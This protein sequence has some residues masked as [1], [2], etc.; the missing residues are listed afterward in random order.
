MPAG[1]AQTTVTKFIALVRELLD[2]S[3]GVFYV[4]NEIILGLQESLYVFGALTGYWRKRGSFNVAPSDLSQFYSLATLLPQYRPRTIPLSQ[5]VTEIQYHLLENPSGIAG[6]GMSGQISIA[7]ILQAIQ[8]ARNLFVID[9]H[10]PNTVHPNFTNSPPPDGL[11]EFPQTSVFVHRA[12]WQDSGGQWANLWRQDAWAFD[13]GTYQWTTEPGAPTAYSEAELAPLQLQIYPPPLSAGNLEA[14]TVDSLE[15]DITDPN[16]LFGLPDEWVHAVKWAALADILTGGGQITDDL[17]GQ[18]CTQRYQQAVTFAKDART[19]I[20]LTCN[21]LPLPIDSLDAMDAGTPF[22]RNQPGPPQVAG[23]LY[24]LLA[25]GPVDQPYN[26][27][28]DVVQAAPVPVNPGD[29]LPIG[30]EN[31][32][33]ILSYV[34][35]YL[36]LKCGGNEF[37]STMVNYD[38]FMKAVSTRKGVNAAKIVYLEPLL[39][40][41]QR[42]EG[43]RPDAVG[44]KG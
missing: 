18:Y 38:Q 17:R 21:G 43:V 7:S 11:V 3:S 26:I 34:A 23:V 28:I 31:L 13:K 2:D 6:T 4:D 20:R 14:V 33:D 25:I 1:Y 35:N 22:W 27:G 39:G 41:W 42:E 16:A 37:K 8:R 40:Q 12:S 15:M 29:F 5:I 30:D 9:C 10:L 44:V 36:T 19:I 24:D 32:D